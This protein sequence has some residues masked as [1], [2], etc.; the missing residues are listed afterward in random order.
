MHCRA[1]RER[2]ARQP[3][4]FDHEREKNCMTLSFV[5][6]QCA[7]LLYHW[8]LSFVVVYRC[9]VSA[10]GCTAKTSEL[11]RVSDGW[12]IAV[13]ISTQFSVHRTHS[14]L[15]A[16]WSAARSNDSSRRVHCTNVIQSR[17]DKRK[18]ANRFYFFDDETTLK[19]SQA[20][21][22]VFAAVAVVFWWLLERLDGFSESFW[23]PQ[24]H[25]EF[26]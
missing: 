22:W 3:S 10:A 17:R 5:I 12:K 21:A 2:E 1:S 4:T 24:I 15:S 18:V 14:T 25:C 11:S 9:S 26:H 6:V 16:N 8:N 7:R 13:F 20:W 23:N 19:R